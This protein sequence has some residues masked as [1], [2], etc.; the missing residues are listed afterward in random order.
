L[1]NGVRVRDC[2]SLRG[3]KNDQCRSREGLFLVSHFFGIYP[4]YVA[5][6]RAR[7]AG[8][9]LFICKAVRQLW[10]KRIFFIEMGATCAG[11]VTEKTLAGLLQNLVVS[12]M[13]GKGKHYRACSG[14]RTG[15]TCGSCRLADLASQTDIHRITSLLRWDCRIRRILAMPGQ[16]SRFNLSM[17]CSASFLLCLS[18]YA[19]VRRHGRSSRSSSTLSGACAGLNCSDR[20]RS[21]R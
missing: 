9:H 19:S 18:R 1:I 11:Y 6:W 14:R 17:I 5:G 7:T 8:L 15:T 12:P 10:Q 16:V 13:K 21:A 3:R 20:T 2:R 4:F